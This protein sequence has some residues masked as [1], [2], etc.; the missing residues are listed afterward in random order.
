MNNQQ[1]S[2][3]T[4]INEIMRQGIN[5]KSDDISVVNDIL[6]EIS[7]EK[8]GQLQSGQQVTL[9]QQ[10]Q[11]Q[12]QQQEMEQKQR[13][14]IQQQA[15]KQHEQMIAQQNALEDL[16]KSNQQKDE[17]LRQM[18]KENNNKI[19]N[20]TNISLDLLN[21]FKPTIVLFSI[22]LVLTLPVINKF[23]CTSI[24]I[25]ENTIYS[26]LRCFI[27][28]VIFFLINKFV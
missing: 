23:I 20:K 8:Q 11:Q 17:I 16:V 25:E 7:A 14:M 12:Q 19:D 5:S 24:G 15:Q 21:E 10:Q 3:V 6:S 1:N 27:I 28:S 26:V 22:I 9:Q 18:S 13:M 4:D 2:G